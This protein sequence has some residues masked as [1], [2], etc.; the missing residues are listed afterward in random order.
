M[1]TLN[2]NTR[3]L[4]HNINAFAEELLSTFPDELSVVHLVNSGSEANELALRM[5][6]AFTGQK[7]MISVEVGYHGNTTGC[8]SISSYK[9]DGKGGSGAPEHTHVVPLPDGYRGLYRGENSGPG[10]AKHV[11]EKI[12]HIHS[13]GR[14][15]AAFICES[16]ISCG[17][18]IE[19]PDHYLEQAYAMVRD[20][21]GICIAD[22]VQVGCGRLGKTF[23]GFQLHHVV[24]DIVTIGKPIG[25]GHP[26]AAV[27]CTPQVAEAFANG[28]E[29][30]NTFGGNPVSCAIGREVLRVV[31]EESLQENA[32]AVG[33]YLK[34]ELTKMQ[35]EF[36]LIGEV[37]G[38][39]L[40][41]GI[42]LTDQELNPQ[43]EKAAY[44]ADRMKDLGFLMSTDGK[45]VN[46]MKIKPPLVFNRSQADQLLDALKRVFREDMMQ[47]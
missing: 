31:K 7:D 22:E 43:T 21:G 35:K 33:N 5:A 11:Q 24:P 18:Q 9:F 46:V 13:L 40:F 6:Y 2:T 14:K 32:L 42:E 12:N 20:A 23:W 38:Q 47:E 10:Y 17:G 41:L 34:E 28:M 27:V 39:G 44:L 4:H 45:D 1:A 29:Y 30:F 3:Y 26:L 25:N 16:I 8:V 37:R 15:P 36:P 19:L